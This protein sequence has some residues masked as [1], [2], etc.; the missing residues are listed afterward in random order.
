VL[1]RPDHPFTERIEKLAE[2]KQ[3]KVEI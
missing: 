2:E 3:I 1:K